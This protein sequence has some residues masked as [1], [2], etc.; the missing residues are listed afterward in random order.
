MF[1]RLPLFFLLFSILIVVPESLHG[2]VIKT[3]FEQSV[4][5]EADRYIGTDELGSIF[6]IHEQI[7]Y[8]VHQG[9]I[10]SYANAALGELSQVDL[11]NPFK[12]VLFYADFNAVIILDNNLNELTEMIE[13]TNNTGFNNVLFVAGSSQNNIWLYADDQKLHLYDYNRLQE[14]HS[15]QAITFYEEGFQ[16][17]G[18]TSTFKSLWLYGAQQV[19]QF[20]E[21]G[22]LIN[23]HEFDEL[24]SVRRFKKHF[25]IEDTNGWSYWNGK[26][27]IPLELDSKHSIQDLYIS[28]N[29]ISLFDGKYVHFYQLNL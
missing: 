25:F 1:L 2:Q 5:I 4:P 18:M 20:N 17:K 28:E 29:K 27:L 11:F 3:R 24:K 6:Y 7:L 19:Y 21:Y 14:K 13:F 23:E 16:P 10:F 8:K 12:I 22:T 15:T 9:R 26:S